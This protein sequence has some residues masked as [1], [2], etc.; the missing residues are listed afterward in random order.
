MKQFI[1]PL[2]W[3]LA[4]SCLL[5]AFHSFA[6]TNSLQGKVTDESNQGI[7]GV[8]V[9]EKGTS[10]GTVTGTDGS[11]SLLLNNSN[12]TVVF[13]YIGYATEE[14]QVSKQTEINVKLL[15]DLKTLSEV[16]VVGYGEQQKK[17]L[18]GAISSVSSKDIQ[19]IHKI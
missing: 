5:I 13:S 18:T 19:K 9:L 6:Q 3:V 10:N 16:V 7:P 11:Y 12:S 8:N 4:L 17:D 15:P 2:K 14:I 1:P